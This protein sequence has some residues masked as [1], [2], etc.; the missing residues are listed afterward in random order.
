M[1]ELTI[2]RVTAAACLPLRREILRKGLTGMP[3]SFDGDDDPRAIHLAAYLGERQVGVV[4]LLPHAPPED[5]GESADPPGWQLRGMA[6]EPDCRRT[7]VGHKLLAAVERELGAELTRA[8]LWCNARIE[9]VP[10]YERGGWETV[11]ETFDVPRIGPHY[12]MRWRAPGTG[13]GGTGA[14]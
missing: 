9:A 13:A 10:F 5:M 1:P 6:V 7:G 8:I 3:A 4:T 12:R 14:G 2:R 11:G